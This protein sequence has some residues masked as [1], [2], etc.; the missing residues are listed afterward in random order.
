MKTTR[1][2][3]KTNGTGAGRKAGDPPDKPAEENDIHPFSDS[4][5]FMLRTTYRVAA[6]ALQEDLRD[7]DVPV[8][9][10]PFLRHLWKRDGI[11]QREL[12]KAVGLMQPNTNAALK[13]L[14]RRGWVRQV[15]DLEDRRKLKIFLTPKGRRL[16]D[17]ALPVAVRLQKRALIG[18]SDEQISE[19]KAIL[20]KIEKNLTPPDAE[21]E[22]PTAAS[23]IT[24]RRLKPAPHV[25]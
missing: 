18:L 3:S 23:G 6:R 4:I 24:S 11:T 19:L 25:N 9:S 1:T 15:R 14:V 2:A 22:R 21:S 5:A 20:R 10:W 7:H 13:K 16:R 12:T 8:A 17:S